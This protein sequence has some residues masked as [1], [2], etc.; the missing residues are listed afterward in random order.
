M[1]TSEKLQWNELRHLPRDR[2]SKQQ[3][4]GDKQCD[5]DRHQSWESGSHFNK[6]G[7]DFGRNQIDLLTVDFLAS[8]SVAQDKARHRR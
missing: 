3:T 5:R 4:A 1:A 7:E 8:H 6:K 2:R